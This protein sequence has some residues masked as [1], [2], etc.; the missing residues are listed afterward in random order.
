MDQKQAITKRKIK[1]IKIPNNG[2]NQW[3]K[4]IF[5]LMKKAQK[6]C[7]FKIKFYKNMQNDSLFQQK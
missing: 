6:Q 4:K 7:N 2:K 1:K 5:F 3:D